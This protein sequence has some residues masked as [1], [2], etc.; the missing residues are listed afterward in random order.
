MA[1]KFI[2][3]NDQPFKND[4]L[5]GRIGEESQCPLRCSFYGLGPGRHFL[6]EPLFCNVLILGFPSDHFLIV[7]KF[8]LD[9]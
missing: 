5:K 9:Y 8:K 6:W 3:D 4:P 2:Y 1:I 7:S